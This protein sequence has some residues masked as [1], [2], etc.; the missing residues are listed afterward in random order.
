[1]SES[2]IAK[3]EKPK[4]K[5]VIEKTCKIRTPSLDIGEGGFSYVNVQ[6]IM[7]KSMCENCIYTFMDRV[8]KV[9]SK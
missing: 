8:E 2:E 9:L 5:E 7:P 1:I 3:L 6:K 4:V